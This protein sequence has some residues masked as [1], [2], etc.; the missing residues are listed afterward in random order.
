MILEIIKIS[1]AIILG[2]L[3]LF[4][5]LFLFYFVC[6]VIN[7]FIEGLK[8]SYQDTLHKEGVLSFKELVEKKRNHPQK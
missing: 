8:T 1:S 5:I 6:H 3:A 7:A 4:I 2:T